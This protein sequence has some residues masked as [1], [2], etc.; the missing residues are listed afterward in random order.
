MSVSTASSWVVSFAGL[1]SPVDVA[2]E[3]TD[4]AV[5]VNVEEGIR[6]VVWLGDAVGLAYARG[7]RLTY[8]NKRAAA[9]AGESC[10][11]KELTG[12]RR[13]G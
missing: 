3:F 12:E 10:L 1:N 6:H 5:Y 4:Q 13:R 7:R 9:A 11:L 2:W 8:G